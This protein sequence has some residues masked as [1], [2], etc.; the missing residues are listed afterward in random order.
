MKKATRDMVKGGA[1][2]TLILVFMDNVYV[3]VRKIFGR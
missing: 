2:A 1:V 3:Q